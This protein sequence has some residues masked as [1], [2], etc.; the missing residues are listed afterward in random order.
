MQRD[1]VLVLVHSTGSHTSQ[2]LHVR[3]N[4]KQQTQVDT[5][6]PDVRAGLTADPEDTEVAIVVELDE[7][8]L[9]DGSD[10]QLALDGRDQRRA[11]EKRAGEQLKGTRELG[12]TAGDLVVESY[13][14][15]V[16]LSGSLLGLDQARGTVDTDD[17][18]SCDFRIEGTAVAGLLDTEHALD[19]CD[20]FVGGGVR[21]LVELNGELML[22]G[23]AGSA[24]VEFL[25]FMTPEETAE[26]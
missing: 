21:G 5:E 12:L 24:G 25:T 8:G 20:D 23:N 2:L 1:Q 17:Q 16:F 7:L 15:D 4:T 22:V 6:R 26:S 10:T 3:A 13:D 18:T 11:L 9:V 19:P 14:G